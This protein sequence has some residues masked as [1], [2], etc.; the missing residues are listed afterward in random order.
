V[1]I[2]YL[3]HQLSTILEGLRGKLLSFAGKHSAELVNMK[4]PAEA[5]AKLDERSKK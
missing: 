2:D 4:T 5:R 1:S 3:E